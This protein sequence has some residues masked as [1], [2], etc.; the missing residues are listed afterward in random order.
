MIMRTD[1][2]AIALILCECPKCGY[3]ID[4]EQ[5]EMASCDYKCPR[6]RKKTLSKFNLIIVARTGKIIR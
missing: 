3:R 1:K 5:K 4:R 6:C 2:I